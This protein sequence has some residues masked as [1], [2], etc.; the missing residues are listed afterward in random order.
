[1]DNRFFEATDYLLSCETVGVFGI[2]SEM[3][4]QKSI[5]TLV[6]AS[7]DQVYLFDILSYKTSKFHPNL[8]TLLESDSVK[9]VVHD[10]RTLVDCLYHCHKTKLVNIFDTQVKFYAKLFCLLTNLIG[11]RFNVKQKGRGA[12][13]TGKGSV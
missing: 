3:G 10:S 8:K 12:V 9:K 7:W 5:S 11:C 1:M 2:G 6:L 13:K 4:R